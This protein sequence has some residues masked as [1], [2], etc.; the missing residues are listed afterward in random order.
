MDRMTTPGLTE[1]KKIQ[2]FEPEKIIIG[3]IPVYIFNTG[4][5]EV[6][7][8]ELIFDAGSRFH[9]HPLMAGQ[10]NE[11]I[12]EG[13][14]SRTSAEIA[15]IFDFFGAYIQTECTSDYASVTLYTLTKFANETVALLVEIINNPNYP[16]NEL[17]TYM[18]QEKQRLLVEME[19]VD[20]LVR[21]HFND[22]LFKG[23]AYGYFPDPKDYDTLTRQ[24]ILAFHHTNYQNGINAIIVAGNLREDTRKYLLNT[25]EHFTTKK[26]NPPSLFNPPE[27]IQPVHKFIEKEDAVQNAIRIGKRLFN[28]THPDYPK[29]TVLNTIL[30]GY[31]G[32]RLMTNIR[33]EKGYTYGIG[34]G[35]VSL[36]QG[37]Y[38]YIS[39]D[40][41]A[42]VYED[43]IKEIYFEIVKLQEEKIPDT[44]LSL[45]R[46]YL[47][48]SF[49]RSID[50][51]FALAERFKSILLSGLDYDYFYNY[52]NVIK[53]ISSEELQ[54]LAQTYLLPS[55]MTQVIV[56]KK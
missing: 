9:L 37:G 55:E 16:E 27:A 12:D 49:Q 24:E 40:V 41:G 6:L 32:S 11:L 47:L 4:T 28:R 18:E 3:N 10:V 14:N 33:E 31:F 22:A 35:L 2:L 8:I 34:S 7:R 5:Q 20:Y 17:V 36:S 13:T 30:G 15:G 44:E 52:L 21:K 43:A 46:N 45:V 48:G 51:P 26:G 56:G 29:L 42:A 23:H 1:P 19:K 25:F 53:N 38:F 54:K 39:T 50:G